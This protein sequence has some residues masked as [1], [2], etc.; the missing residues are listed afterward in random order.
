[1]KQ[2]ILPSIMASNQKELNYLFKKLKGVT[3]HLHFDV[4]D[5]KFVPKK[6]NYFSFKLKKGFT[7]SAHLMIN[8]PDKWIKKNLNR[9]NLFIPQIETIKD[10]ESH[11]SFMRE[12]KQKIAFAIKPETSLKRI[13]PHLKEID[14][15]L[16]LT[17]HPGFYGARFLYSPLRK[18]K[19][20]RKLNPNI[21]IIID[22]GMNPKTIKLARQADHWVSGSF[23]TKSEN[24]KKAISELKKALR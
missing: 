14:Y 12:K 18:I 1:M 16:I 17:V 15:V 6:S 23:V 11:I 19:K 22:G 5:G 21:K 24:P 8:H 20:I 13:K 2:K 10:L 3:K 9:I 4:G 7:Y